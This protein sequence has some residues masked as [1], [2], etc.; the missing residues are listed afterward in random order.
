MEPNMHGQETGNSPSGSS[1]AS[2]SSEKKRPGTDAH[3]GALKNIKNYSAL[4]Q[5]S[6]NV[7][8]A[9]NRK[10]GNELGHLRRSFSALN[11]R[12]DPDKLSSLYG[13]NEKLDH[14]I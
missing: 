6:V 9:I 11:F 1:S 7:I 4:L 13:L 3:P 2:L 14:P 10:E 12:L 8:D 5:V